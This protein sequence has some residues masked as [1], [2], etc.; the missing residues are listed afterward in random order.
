MFTVDE[1]INRLAL[2]DCI[3]CDIIFS[4]AVMFDLHNHLL[5]GTKWCPHRPRSFHELPT[6]THLKLDVLNDTQPFR[7]VVVVPTTAL[8]YVNL[9][10]VHEKL[11]LRPDRPIREAEGGMTQLRRALDTNFAPCCSRLSSSGAR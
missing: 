2:M 10:R 4:L 6:R 7:T 1:V 9:S 3:Q 8:E 5:S 11:L